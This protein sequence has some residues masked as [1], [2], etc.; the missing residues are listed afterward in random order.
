MKKLHGLISVLSCCCWLAVGAGAQT[1]KVNWKMNA[2]FLDYKT[3]A[4]ETGKQQGSDFYR[5]WVRQDVDA[6]LAKKGL[7]NVSVNQNPDLIVVYNMMSQELLDSTTTSDGFGWGG[8]PWGYWGAWGGWGDVGPDI[9]TTETEPR[10]L[11]ILTV[12][13][14]D[15]KTKQLVWRGQ[16]TEDS[17]SNSQKGDE[18][19]VQKSVQKMFDRFPPKNQK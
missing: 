19:Q 17:I 13:L 5:Q 6:A 1:V 10:M 11:G 9:S 3:Y 16:A 14:V 2:P 15:A 8:G 18:K 4:W 12:D 7:Q